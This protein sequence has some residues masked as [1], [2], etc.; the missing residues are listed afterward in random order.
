[1]EVP[2]VQVRG[3]RHKPLL[4]A[5]KVGMNSRSLARRTRTAAEQ[6]GKQTTT[7]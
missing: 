6:A 3:T 7:T 4:E 1:M 2:L 5:S